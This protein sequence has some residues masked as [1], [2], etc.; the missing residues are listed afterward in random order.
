MTW[1]ISNP[2]YVYMDFPYEVSPDEHGY[3]WGTR[4]SDEQKI[5]SFAPNNLPQNAETSVD[6]D[7]NH[8]TAKSD[9]PWPG[10]YGLS[11]QLWSEV[12][13]TDQQMEYMIYPRAVSLAERAWH[14][15]QLGA[16]LQS[17]P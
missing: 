16:G 5:F 11:A 3:Y 14:R 4:F 9:K 8:F 1:V 7:G 6:R 13:R 10:A 15:R 17:W 12:V 2:D